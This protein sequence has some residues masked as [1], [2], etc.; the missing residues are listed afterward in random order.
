MEHPFRNL[1]IADVVEGEPI[2]YCTDKAAVRSH[3]SKR[4]ALW[5][6]VGGDIGIARQ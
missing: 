4:L 1:R 3:E 2:P 5:A 6:N